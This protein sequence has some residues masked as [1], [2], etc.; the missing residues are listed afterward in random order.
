MLSHWQFFFPEHL[1][2]DHGCWSVK[3][4]GCMGNTLR[5]IAGRI[6]YDASLNSSFESLEMAE[7]APLTLKDPVI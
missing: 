2:H 7:R 1:W 3:Y 6:S 5:M 4:F